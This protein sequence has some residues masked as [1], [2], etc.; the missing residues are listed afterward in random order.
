[1]NEPSVLFI[2]WAEDC[3]RSDNIARQ[4]GG[5]SVM[6]YSPEWGSRYATI[7][8]KYVSQAWKTLTLLRETRPSVV[9][10][11][12]PPT[13]AC[14]PVWLYGL[15]TGTPFI[16]DAHS[17]AFLLPRWKRVLFLHRFFSRRALSTLLTNPFLDGIVRSWGARTTIVPDVPVKLPDPRPWPMKA[18][19]NITLV[20]TFS[21][22]EPVHV[23]FEAARA[24]P[25]IQFFVTG[26]PSTADPALLAGKP[27]N[28]TLTGFIPRADY[29][30]LLLASD[31]IMTMTT[32]DN[33]MQR[34]A[35]EAIYAGKPV[36]TANQ[37]FLRQEFARG[38]VHVDLTPDG[39]STGFRR[40]YEN[41]DGLTRE[42]GILRDQKKAR[43]E[44]VSAELREL[45]VR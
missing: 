16:I 32:R 41:L 43:W 36:I 34:G 5:K 1:M 37:P 8:A 12:T 24:S 15:F 40:L 39:I 44:R 4:L 23:F 18:Q 19:R 27:E 17:G 3:S 13:V 31:A 21:T 28:V 14:A 26:D 42:A 9:F 10:V 29:A 11:M 2:S 20:C 35:Y 22:D 25:H 38:T 45:M 7:L 33:T 30:G 6:V